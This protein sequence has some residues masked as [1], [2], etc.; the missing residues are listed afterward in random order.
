[1]RAVRH[2]GAPDWGPKVSEGVEEC[3][4]QCNGMPVGAAALKS[5]WQ[6]VIKFKVYVPCDPAGSE[7]HVCSEPAQACAHKH[8]QECADCCLQEANVKATRTHQVWKGWVSDTAWWVQILLPRLIMALIPGT[9]TPPRSIDKC[10]TIRR[11]RR[12]WVVGCGG[13]CL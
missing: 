2:L 8:A 12:D 11:K 1:M 5:T 3:N 6:Y 4:P 9:H 7:L 13:T 10:K